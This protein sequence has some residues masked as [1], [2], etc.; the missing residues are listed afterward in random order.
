[1]NKER[2]AWL[3]AV[4]RH[5][6]QRRKYTGEPYTNH[7]AEVA[8]IVNSVPH[9]SSM[10]VAA[11]L[12]DVVEDNTGATFDEIKFFFG[13]EVEGLV[14]MLTNVSRK[15]DGNRLVRKT[16]DLQHLA[17]ASAPAQTIK[18]GDIISNTVDIVEHDREF[19][20][21]YLV[22][23]Y[24]ALFVLRQG[25]RGLWRSALAIVASGLKQIGIDPNSIQTPT[26]EH[27]H[28]S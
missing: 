2:E 4:K 22:E 21:V 10:I 1:M 15:E 18:L 24:Q 16:I 25:D 7:T 23:K 26:F 6:N 17:Q 5:G 13:E 8:A 28:K 3:Y 20:K 12:H 27:P 14:R 11:Y 9:T 19:A